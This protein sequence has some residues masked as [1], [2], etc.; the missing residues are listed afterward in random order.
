MSN[1]L[2]NEGLTGFFADSQMEKPSFEAF[3]ETLDPVQ[4][5]RFKQ[6]AHHLVAIGFDEGQNRRAAGNLTPWQEA[7][8]GLVKLDCYL[9]GAAEQQ[10]AQGE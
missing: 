1:L 5:E 9:Q 2:P 3:L 4:Q 7:R 6:L 10:E 8:M